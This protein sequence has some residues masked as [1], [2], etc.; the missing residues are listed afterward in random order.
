MIHDKGTTLSYEDPLPTVIRESSNHP[1]G[2]GGAHNRGAFPFLTSRLCMMLAVFIKV[3]T[4]S[5]MLPANAYV[6]E[7]DGRG[8]GDRLPRQTFASMLS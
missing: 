2:S 4:A 5:Q 8:S 1:A 7:G 6:L 3:V